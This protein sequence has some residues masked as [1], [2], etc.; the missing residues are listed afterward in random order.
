MFNSSLYRSSVAHLSCCC[1]AALI[2]SDT[3]E[4]SANA[5][6][7][8][9]AQLDRFSDIV[10]TPRFSASETRCAKSL[11]SIGFTLS[12]GLCHFSNVSWF[13]C[14]L[15]AGIFGCTFSCTPVTFGGLL[16]CCFL[17]SFFFCLLFTLSCLS[18]N[19]PGNVFHYHF[20]Y[21]A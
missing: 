3:A 2:M 19:S 16:P 8:F 14:C 21:C 6:A 17:Y 13:S 18:R 4:Q 12:H 9:S 20:H 11:S 1:L 5:F 7:A 10:P 15:G